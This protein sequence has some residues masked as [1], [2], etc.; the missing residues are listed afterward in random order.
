MGRPRRPIAPGAGHHP[1][2]ALE[3]RKGLGGVLERESYPPPLIG[4][5]GGRIL[6][7]IIGPMSEGEFVMT[8]SNGDGNG[9][10]ITGTAILAPRCARPR[11]S[12][13]SASGSRP[14]WTA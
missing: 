7:S 5:L 13:I 14:S 11:F 9:E 2:A 3:P 4:R 8:R 6:A 12:T 10:A 1:L